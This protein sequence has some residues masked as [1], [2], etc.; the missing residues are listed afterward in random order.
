METR[1]PRFL[2]AAPRVQ[3]EPAS[4]GGAPA[5]PD[6]PR[7]SLVDAQRR[8]AAAPEA[9]KA[10]PPQPPPP[11]VQETVRVFE[12]VPSPELLARIAGGVDALRL[13]GE[14]LAATARADAL[15]IGFLVARRILEL[16]LSTSPQPLFALIRSALR[17]AGESRTVAVRLH[18]ADLQAIEGRVHEP[19][20]AGLTLSQVKLVPDASLERG[21]CVVETDF[22]TVDG[23]LSTRLA[24][25]ARV[26]AAELGE[27]A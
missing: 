13:Q 19:M 6:K 25:A 24:E 18:P 23:R 10:P 8:A 2:S 1:T 26:L 5:A 11:A 27:D 9:P 7:L 4:F 16:E 12:H 14:R 3:V 20:G 17:R 15:E 22:G 21:D